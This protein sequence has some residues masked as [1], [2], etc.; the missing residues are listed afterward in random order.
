MNLR[1]GSS[2]QQNAR[3]VLFVLI[4]L[5]ATL[6]LTTNSTAQ[7]SVC[8]SSD[9]HARV[10]KTAR[11]YRTPDPDY[12][13]VLG[14]NP[15]KAARIGSPPVNADGFAQPIN[16]VANRNESPGAGTTPKFFCSVPGVVDKDGK[17]VR[18]KIK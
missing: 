18:L 2:M 17:P 12:D 11:V 4:I 13:P 7:Q 5:F 15:T 8:F 6:P 10:E 9:E 1:R 3:D 14:Y 16:C